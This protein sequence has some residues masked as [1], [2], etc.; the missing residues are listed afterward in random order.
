MSWVELAGF[1]TGAVCVVLVVR[2]HIANFPIGIANSVL[3]AP[4][5]FQ[6]CTLSGQYLT[7]GTSRSP[8]SHRPA[9]S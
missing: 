1:I 6:A 9:T 8:C 2:E 7:R 4:D 3:G 5:L